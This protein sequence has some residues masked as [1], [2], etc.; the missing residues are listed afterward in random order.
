MEYGRTSR[1]ANNRGSILMNE[2]LAFDKTAL[3]DH[4]FANGKR[5]CESI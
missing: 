2:I 3:P 4:V 1:T 5:W